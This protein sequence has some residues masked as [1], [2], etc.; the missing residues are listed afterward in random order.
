MTEMRLNADKADLARIQALRAL[1][2]QE[3]NFQI[4]YNACHERGWTDSYLLTGNDVEIGYG[5]IKGREIADRDTVFEF[6]VIPP[7]RKHASRLFRALLDVSRVERIEC[8]SNDLLLSAMMFEF[9]HH[10]HADTILFEAHAATGLVCPGAIFRTRDIG[11]EIFAHAV[12]P[13]GDYV[14]EM[15]GDIVATGGFLLHYN[16]PFADVYMEVEAS[17]RQR[18][19]GSFLV[20][21]IIKQCYAAGRVPAARCGLHNTAS[22]ATLTKA[23]L[24]PCGF[25]LTGDV[26]SSE[27]P[28]G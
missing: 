16:H 6:Y 26:R 17:H 11:D 18:G 8:Q 24:R 27:Q 22:R 14:V 4:R 2:L 1:F 25:M 5:S 9:A 3:A 23:G 19:V 12:E 10:I 21:E 20:Q 13:E 7:L 28:L 15:E